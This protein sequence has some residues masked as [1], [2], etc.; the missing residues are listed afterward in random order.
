[1]ELRYINF[2]NK[3]QIPKLTGAIRKS[4]V[5]IVNVFYDDNYS[6]FTVKCGQRI[7]AFDVVSDSK[8][9]KVN[10]FCNEVH[11]RSNSGNLGRYWLIR[12]IEWRT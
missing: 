10:S 11:V 9:L 4:R 7:E 8:V 3:H 12:Q 2:V 6:H 5:T 1:M